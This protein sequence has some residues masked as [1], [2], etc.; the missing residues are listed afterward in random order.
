LVGAVLALGKDL[1]NS[2]VN[3]VKP[4]TILAWQRK[5]EHQKWNYNDR[6]KSNPGRPQITP[7][8]E[9]LVCR[10][11]RENIWGYERIQ[12]EMQKLGFKISKSSIANILRRNDLPRSPER[13]GLTWQEFLSRHAEVFL[14][15]D[16]FKK[17]VWTFKG[18]KTVFLFFVIHLRTRRVVLAKST[19]SPN[20]QWV[21]QQFR[22]VLWEC[23]EKHLNIRFLLRDNDTYYAQDCD[24]IL[25]ASGIETIRTPF[26]APNANAHAERFVLSIKNECLDHLLIFGLNRLQC[27]IDEYVTYFNGHRP[28]QGIENRVPDEVN[29]CKGMLRSRKSAGLGAAVF[30]EDFLGGLLKS[31]KEG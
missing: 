9:A 12:G 1:M 4:E 8:I 25:A 6:S 29:L 30:R 23:D 16:F 5:L 26:L 31:Y 10:M 24:L 19:F 22:H 18:L 15:T 28:H 17:E 11:A 3:I 20:D 27:I 14:C 21:K 7:E 2:I 13:K